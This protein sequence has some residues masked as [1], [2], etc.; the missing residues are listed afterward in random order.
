MPSR[1]ALIHVVAA[2]LLS[3]ACADPA[4]EQSP[5]PVSPP[6]VESAAVNRYEIDVA[7]KQ[8]AERSAPADAY[9][10]SYQFDAAEDWFSVN[11][12]VWD[13][14]LDP[15]KGRPVHYLEI[16]CFEGRSA[17]WMF[18]NVLTDTGSTLTC[19]DPYQDHVGQAV[20]SRFLANIER[21]GAADRF[22]LIVGFSQEELRKLPLDNY[23]VIYIDG[24]HRAGPVL[25]DAVL[26]WRLLK[27]NG[28]MIFDDYGW[29]LS[30]PAPDRPL[31]GAD[32][33]LEAF[34]S[35]FEVI[36][37][38]YQLILRKIDAG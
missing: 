35:R 32:F 3:L 31:M 21:A 11:I 19:I 25:E 17:I 12:P 24:D 13:A 29:E 36:H 14:A 8:L 20:K 10:K 38:E 1:P 26:S 9:R 23:D 30:R 5:E 37:R 16:G 7:P 15:F 27:V 4:S 34:R 22:K 2:S 18:E 6:S 28:V 33:F